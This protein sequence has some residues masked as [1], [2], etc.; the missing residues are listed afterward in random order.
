MIYIGQAALM[1]SVLAAAWAAA[2]GLLGARSRSEPLARSAGRALVATTV[3]SG[4]ALAALAWALWTDDFTVR[5]V[6]EYSSRAQG[7]A[8]KLGA[9][10]GGQA[11]SLLV[12][13]FMIGAMAVVLVATSG[14]FPLVL[15]SWAYGF[16]GLTAAFFALVT[17]LAAN[18]FVRLGPGEV[19]PDGLGLNPLLQNPW[20]LIH[21]PALLLGYAATTFP[22]AFALGALFSGRLDETWVRLSRRWNLFAFTFLTAGILLG[23]YWAYIELGWG[24]YWAWDPVENAS[25]MPWLVLAALLHSS[26]VQERRGMLRTWNVSLAVLAYLMSIFGTFLTRSGII[27]S[28]HAFGESS[29][30]TWFGVFLLAMTALAVVAVLRRLRA[31]RSDA[32]LTSLVSREAAVWLANLL[33][34]GTTLMIFLLTVFPLLS[35]LTV[36]RKITPE[37]IQ[38]TRVTS[39]WFLGLVVLMALGPILGWKR[40][41]PRALVRA[42][43]VPLVLTLAAVALV[44]VLGA[45]E[46]WS[47]LFFGAALFAA[48]VHLLDFT[49]AVRTRRA[50]HREALLVSVAKLLR[51]HRRRYGG[52]LVH[53]GV[54]LAVIGIAGSSAYR[55]E[56]VFEEI[57]PGARMMVDGYELEY[58]GFDFVRRPTHDAAQV[59]VVARLPGEDTALELLPEMRVYR[60]SNQR[61]SEVSLLPTW[62]PPSVRDLRRTGED[63]YVILAAIDPR[64]GVASFQVLVEPFVNWL[65]LGGVLMLVGL[66]WAAWPTREEVYLLAEDLAGLAAPAGA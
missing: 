4:I 7:A 63:L 45:H 3:L 41:V 33:F 25:F 15:R 17:T 14:R 46:P 47:L 53:L 20:M 55:R 65:W 18:P 39:P 28:V 62:W 24:G 9:V 60:R 19:P 66:H 11:G 38:Y 57:R 40:A 35:E 30:G 32:S 42:T 1:V 50:Q 12:W 27:S 61:T 26:I 64:T 13:L 29:I 10:W 21:P 58:R 51:F 49:R 5:Y 34:T 8:Y 2:A 56:Q 48:L 22:A 23:A 36:G 43:A 59:R 16:T 44:I 37:P 52:Y 31:L 54:V 6:A